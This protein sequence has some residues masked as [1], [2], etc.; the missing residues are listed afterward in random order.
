MHRNLRASNVL[1]IITIFFSFVANAGDIEWSGL[2]RMEGTVINNAILDG[3]HKKTK[4]YGLH[5]LIL[6][7]RI[8]A[9]D[10][11]YIDAQFGV[12]EKPVG[13]QM[14]AY[15]GEGPGNG[16]GADINNSNASAERTSSTEVRISQFYLTWIQEHGALLAGRAPLHFGLGMTYSSGR[17]L[18]DHFADVRDIVG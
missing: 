14:G 12:H 18:F 2:Y 1:F 16:T 3:T 9:A 10:G 6:R 4:E 15:L 13:N 11:L 5:N 7:P 17:G 8:V